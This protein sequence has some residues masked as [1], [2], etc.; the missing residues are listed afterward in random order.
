MVRNRHYYPAR[1]LEQLA[2]V[3]AFPATVVLAPGGYGKTTA[4]RDFVR[5]NLPAGTVLEWCAVDEEAPGL[6]WDRLCRVLARLDPEAGRALGAIGFSA[7]TAGAGKIAEAME[8]MHCR[9]PGIIVLDDFH[10]LQK[11]IPAAV[12]STLLSHQVPDLHLVFITRTARPFPDGFFEESGAHMITKDDLRLSAGDIYQCGRQRRQPV[13]SSQANRVYHRTEGWPAGVC[14]TLRQLKRGRGFAPG[15]D[16]LRLMESIV[17]RDLGPRQRNMLL[18]LAPV[19]EVD[20]AGI[21][22]LLETDSLSDGVLELLDETPFIRYE[23]HSGR[24]VLHPILRAMLLRRLDAADTRTRAACY[25]RAGQRHAGEGRVSAALSCFAEIGDVESFLS[26][27]LTKMTLARI[28]GVPFTEL[29]ARLLADCP[30]ETKGRHVISLLRIA[31]AFLGADQ[32]ERADALLAEIETMIRQVPDAG[33]RRRLQ[34]E[35]GL[36][37]AFRELPDIIKMEPL[38]REAA[39][40][41]GGR[42]RTLAPDEPLFFGLPIMVFLHQKAGR[43][44]EERQALA[45]IVRLLDRLTGVNS[46]ADLLLEAEWALFRGSPA[47]AELLVH[48]AAYRS[49]RSPQWPVRAGIVDLKAQLAFKHGRGADL[50]KYVQALEKAVGNDA[51]SPQVCRLLQAGQNVWAGKIQRIPQ[52]VREGRIPPDAPAWVRIFQRFIHIAVLLQQEDYTR[53]LGAAEAA[54]MDCRELGYSMVEMY[55]HLMAAV[56]YL[57]TGRRDTALGHVREA[58]AF[59]LPDRLFLPFMEFGWM[60]DGLAEAPGEVAA[61]GRT[62]TDNWKLLL[63]QASE[64]DAPPH[65]LTW[66]EM[67]V[68]VLA[69]KGV[70]NKEIAAALF[71]SESTVK[72]H[73]RSVFSKLNIDRRGKLSDIL[74]RQ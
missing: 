41:I 74:H 12:L 9:P 10:H 66:R 24:Y 20:P 42:C 51:M 5:D 25:R 72:F 4:V 36:V 39:D 1:V 70:S 64:N 71:I 69:A 14:H 37:R 8:R 63:R 67:D 15:V 31:Y 43:L 46:G 56:G 50:A 45:H 23:A 35:W 7:T 68:A 40:R 29:A 2:G 33:Q 54:V 65:G 60:L 11:Q 27:P 47:Q 22:F 59:T 26:Q 49:D 21:R 16:L 57:R 58:L 34:G 30:G 62:M 18:R 55:I 38:I 28:D 48:Q 19:S 44:P 6:S 17:W 61:T 73:L 13:S 53:L 32:R 3:F 52:W